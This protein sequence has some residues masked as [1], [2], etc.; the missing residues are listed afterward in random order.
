MYS[1][2]HARSLRGQQGVSTCRQQGMGSYRVERSKKVCV[3]DFVRG[4]VFATALILAPLVLN[5]VFVFASY[6]NGNKSSLA[7]ASQAASPI[8]R[9]R[10]RKARS[11]KCVGLH[12][13]CFA[14]GAKFDKLAKGQQPAEI[15][16]AP[17]SFQRAGRRSHQGFICNK[18]KITRHPVC[19]VDIIV[20]L[21]IQSIPKLR[22]YE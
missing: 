19:R 15:E 3:H 12:G 4:F 17:T 22:I 13:R 10:A 1:A 20:Q 6:L 14:R 2:Y 16:I 5:T 11:V 7:I 8:A 21:N 9:N 18:E